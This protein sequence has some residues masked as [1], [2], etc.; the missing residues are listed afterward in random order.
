MSPT[1]WKVPGTAKKTLTTFF[2][3]PDPETTV[4]FLKMNCVDFQGKCQEDG[5]DSQMPRR[6]RLLDLTTWG[7]VIN[8]LAS[9]YYRYYRRWNNYPIIIIMGIL[10]SHYNNNSYRTKG[11]KVIKKRCSP[12][13]WWHHLS[14][15][16]PDAPC[17]GNS[18]HRTFIICWYTSYWKMSI[19]IVAFVYWKAFCSKPPSSWRSWSHGWV[20]MSNLGA[21]KY[22]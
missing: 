18:R 4:K 11:W 1:L 16:N 15:C 6:P 17:A 10:I 14:F 19:S 9:L 20:Q 13:Q 22:S 21:F 8:T 7:L 2:F 5:I 3:A 12:D